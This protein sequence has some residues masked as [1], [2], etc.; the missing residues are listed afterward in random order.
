MGYTG[1]VVGPVV[2]GALA[3]GFGLRAG[4]V[5]LAAFAAFVAAAPALSGA[6]VGRGDGAA[7]RGRPDL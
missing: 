1:F 6:V 2:V 4:L 7:H 3:A 5:L